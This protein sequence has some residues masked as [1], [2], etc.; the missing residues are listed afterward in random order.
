MSTILIILIVTLIKESI[1][2]SDY[3]GV[4]KKTHN[5]QPF[6]ETNMNK[7]NLNTTEKNTFRPINIYVDSTNLDDYDGNKNIILEGIEK[8]KE[9]LKQLI[10]VKPLSYNISL[11]EENLKNFVEDTT[12]IDQNILNTSIGINTDLLIFIKIGRYSYT[13]NSEQLFMDPDTKR[14][15]IGTIEINS[16]FDF[17]VANGRQYISVLLLHQMTHIL[18]FLYDSFQYYGL[19]IANII[20]NRGYNR[21]DLQRTYVII[22]ELFQLA[23]KYYNCYDR[24][25]IS[26]VEL[27]NQDD[28]SSKP[29]HWEARTLLGEYMN[30]DIYT[31]EQ[32]ISEFTLAL[33]EKSGWY[34]VNYYTGGLMRFGKHKGCGFLSAACDNV[35]NSKNEFFDIN[36]FNKPSCSSGRQ[37]RVYGITY[38]FINMPSSKYNVFGGGTGGIEFADYCLGF[39]PFIDEEKNYYYVGSCKIG[40]NSPYGAIITYLNSENVPNKNLPKTLGERFEKNSFCTLTSVFEKSSNRTELKFDENNEIIHPMC[41]LMYCSQKSLTIQ[42]T[43]YYFVCPRSGGKMKINNNI[44]EGYLYCPDFNLICTGTTICNDIFD[45]VDSKSEYI[46]SD[47]EYEIKTSQ[48]ANE[49]KVETEIVTG[50]ELSENGKCPKFC[51]ECKEYYRCSSCLENY[52]YLGEKEGNKTSSI[53]CTNESL[54]TGYYYKSS[55]NIYY[56]C[57]ANCTKCSDGNLCE[58]CHKYYV[59]SSDSK[60]CEERVLNCEVYNDTNLDCEKC[61]NGYAFF[62]DNRINCYIIDTKTNYTID[63]GV[64]Y[65]P[66]NT[67][68]NYCKECNEPYKCTKCD[69]DYYF[70]EDNRTNCF[71]GINLTKYYTEDNGLSYYPCY[72]EIKNCSTCNNKTICTKCEENYFFIKENRRRCYSDNEIYKEQYYTKD[73]GFSYYPCNEAILNCLKCNNETEC[74]ECVTNYFFLGDNR[75]HCRNDNINKKKYYTEDNG[76]SYYPCNTHFPY[77]DECTNSTTCT[78]CITNYG[79]NQTDRTKCISIPEKKYYTEDGGISYYPCKT[80]FPGCDECESKTKCT[81]CINGSFFIGNNRTYCFDHIENNKYYTE[82]GGISY[83]PC[84]TSIKFCDECYGRYNCSKCDF[85]YFF[86]KIDRTKCYSSTDVDLKRYYSTDGNISYYLCDEIMSKCQ[87]CDLPTYCNKCYYSY[88]FIG[89]NRTYCKNDIDKKKYYTEDNGISYYPCNTHF[90]YCDECTNSTT[91]TRCITNYGFNQTDRTKCISIPEKKYY[92]EDGGISYYPCKTIFP[93]CDECESKTKCTKCINGSFFIGNNRTYCFDNIDFNKYYTEDGGISYYPCDTEVRYCDNCTNKTYCT[94]CKNPYFFI[95]YERAKCVNNINK[96]NYYTEDN[97][98][99][100]FPCSGKMPNCEKCNISSLCLKCYNNY[101]FIENTRDECVG[102]NLKK[103]FTENNGISYIPCYSGVTNCDECYSRNYCV[104]C[105]TLYAL[106]LNNQSHC[107]NE[108]VL[109]SDK[110][111]FKYNETHY[112]KCSEQILNCDYCSSA[113]YCTQCET[114][115]YFVNDN[116]LTCVNE[117]DITP[118]DEYYQVDSLNYYSCGYKKVI[119]NCQKCT[120]MTFC[121]IC[122][123][124]FAFVSDIFTKCYRKSDLEI[125]YY[126]NKDGTIYYPCINNCDRCINGIECNE[127][128]KGYTSIEENTICTKCIIQLINITQNLNLENFNSLVNEYINSNKEELGGVYHYINNADFFTTTVFKL[129]ECTAGLLEKNYFQIN[130]KELTTKLNETLKL[131]KTSF[132]FYFISNCGKSLL[133]AFKTE[134]HEKIEIE[135]SCPECLNTNIKITNNF[136]KVISKKLSGGV[137]EVIKEKNIDIFEDSNDFYKKIC[138]GFTICNIDVPVKERK[139]SF[140]FGNNAKEVICTDSQCEITSKTI[141]N[142]TG[143]CN[144]QLNYDFNYILEPGNIYSDSE[145]VLNI[146]TKN[147]N[148]E[149]FGC[150]SEGFDASYFAKNAGFIIF[151][152]FIV[153]QLLCFGAFIFCKSVSNNIMFKKHANPPPKN[154]TIKNVLFIEDFDKVQDINDPVCVQDAEKEI[155]PRDDEDLIDEEYTE[156]EEIEESENNEQIKNSQKLKI[157]NKNQ[158]YFDNEEEKNTDSQLNH[159]HLNS[160]Y[161]EKDEMFAD[162]L[163]VSENEKVKNTKLILKD[164]EKEEKLKV[165]NKNGKNKKEKKRKKKLAKS[166][167]ELSSNIGSQATDEK[168]SLNSNDEVKIMQKTITKDMDFV[169][170][171]DAKKRKKITFCKFYWFLL[172]LKQPILRLLSFISC[173]GLP[174][175]YIPIFIKIIDL[176]FMFSLNLF[177]NALHLGQRYFQR[178]YIYFQNKYDIKLRSANFKVSGGEMFAFGMR[179]AVGY[180]LISFILCLVIQELIYYYFL[181]IRKKISDVLKSDSEEDRNSILENIKKIIKTSRINFIYMFIVNLV[182]MLLFYYYIINFCGTYR[183]GAADLFAAFFWTFIFLQIIP[184]IVCFIFAVFRYSA[185]IKNNENLYK[186]SNTLIY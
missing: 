172:G 186:I 77:C 48:I 121:K 59:K 70:L 154:K 133:G 159:K 57:I 49:L 55:E 148:F 89:D 41:Y 144:C 87:E 64:S 67:N 7:L 45:C 145:N 116:H 125:G 117:S 113:S 152:I 12:K 32:V 166:K 151:I 128:S 27:E 16:G 180:A 114:N 93:G 120:N 39:T 71:T 37:S 115:Y 23:E 61:K 137:L 146:K 139:K 35:P 162:N 161:S 36:D 165:D 65:Y 54:D 169:A 50:Y 66:C 3:C 104:R 1:L 20:N 164:E 17:T 75:T 74:K 173:L 98:I 13:G 91:C 80:I 124:D 26:G 106:T 184:F 153:L 40:E 118:K 82:D 101:Y 68:I 52:K 92:T 51:K 97:G 122:K 56:P 127:C 181:S 81:K 158:N 112:K 8:S 9:T 178:K 108:S 24:S 171:K 130:T 62:K 88:F 38:T 69:D 129:W 150:V 53:K 175:S 15:I 132:T 168:R 123:P 140:Y 34:K 2:S 63:N 142:L 86:I 5:I 102:I 170:F 119:E 84:N 46:N 14:P 94:L 163:E 95:E 58:K 10:N 185:L 183:G 109:S 28:D 96:E 182:L 179:K 136:A 176:L 11:T 90:P 107:Y 111:Y 147:N 25:I 174:E 177:F 155:Q 42:I 83:Y 160:N 100:Y 76:I 72:T 131:P 19:G 78:R 167:D 73:G 4:G 6:P 110:S 31:P 126:P 99:S 141:N 135:S 157:L 134:N 85:S 44:Y 156:E 33:L 21:L 18:G 47:Y 79:F 60:K 29:N 138:S 103:Y 43:D 22:P 105:N 30:R 149:V 143:G